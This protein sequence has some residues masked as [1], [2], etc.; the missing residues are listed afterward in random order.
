MGTNLFVVLGVERRITAGEGIS[1][2]LGKAPL[3]LNGSKDSK[4]VW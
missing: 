2:M 4:A 1:F 3:N